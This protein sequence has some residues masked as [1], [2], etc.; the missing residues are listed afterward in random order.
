MFLWFDV[1]ED[2]QTLADLDNADCRMC[3]YGLR[4]NVIFIIL[5]NAELCCIAGHAEKRIYLVSVVPAFESHT[6]F[7]EVQESFLLMH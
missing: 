2:I 5:N 6:P 3:V 1:A 4:R 7:E